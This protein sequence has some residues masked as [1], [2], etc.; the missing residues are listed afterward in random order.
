MSTPTLAPAGN[1]DDFRAWQ[2]ELDTAAVVP[3]D[4]PRLP[5]H[6]SRAEERRDATAQIDEGVAEWLRTHGKGA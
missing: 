6:P 4:G 3:L 5:Y 1:F 2:H